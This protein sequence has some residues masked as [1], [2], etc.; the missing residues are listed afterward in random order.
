MIALLGIVFWITIKGGA[1]VPSNILAKGLFW[2]EARL[3]TFF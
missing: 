3:S 1:N 2:I